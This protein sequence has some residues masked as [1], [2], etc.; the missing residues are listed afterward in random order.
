MLKMNYILIWNQN[1]FGIKLGYLNFYL[2][3]Y[4][5]KQ[6]KTHTMA[7]VKLSKRDETLLSQLAIGKPES[8][9]NPFSGASVVLDGRGVALYDYVKGCE[10][11]G[12]WTKLNQGL[13]L[14]RK[15]YPSEYM[16]LLD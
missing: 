4:K 14:F 8:I 1:I 7:K 2:Y 11:T 12:L 16:T 13:T 6:I 15:L 3:L 5:V 9:T 10:V